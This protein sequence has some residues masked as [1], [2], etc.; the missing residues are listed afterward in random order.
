MGLNH[1]HV[2]D[3]QTRPSGWVGGTFDCRSYPAL[4]AMVLHNS[5]P[6]LRMS[7][8][9]RINVVYWPWVILISL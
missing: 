5:S 7:T 1:D 4:D 8:F 9:F 3:S 6:I 2:L